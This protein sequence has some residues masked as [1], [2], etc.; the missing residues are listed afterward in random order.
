MRGCTHTKSK[1]GGGR[2]KSYQKILGYD[3][4]LFCFFYCCCYLNLSVSPFV[5]MT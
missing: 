2:E 5:L 3:I 1:I 4:M